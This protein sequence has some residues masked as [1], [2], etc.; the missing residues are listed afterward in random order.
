M[1]K[2]LE[3]CALVEKK[4]GEDCTMSLATCVENDVSVRVIDVFYKEKA[5]FFTTHTSSKKMKQIALNPN[6]AMCKDLFNMT[7]TAV[8]LGSPLLKKNSSIRDQVKKVFYKFYDRHV[9]ENDSGTCIV[10]IDCQ[11]ILFFDKDS[12]YIIDYDNK[13]VKQTPFHND[14]IL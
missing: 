14:I 4:Y 3:V 1:N 5:F 7:G 11:W 9:N 2:F 10:K 8:K 12:K 13:T 6:V